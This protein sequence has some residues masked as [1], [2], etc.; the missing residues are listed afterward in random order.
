MGKISPD[1]IKYLA[2]LLISTLG[3]MDAKE[4]DNIVKR[5][6]MTMYNDLLG[7]EGEIKDSSFR[8]CHTAGT[9]FISDRAFVPVAQL[10]AEIEGSNHE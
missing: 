8:L 2:D 5:V 6:A 4:A 3:D 1:D 10:N 7:I 9:S